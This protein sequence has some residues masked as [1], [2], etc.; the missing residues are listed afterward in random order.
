MKLIQKSLLEG[1][2]EFELLEEEVRVRTKTLLKEKEHIVT[3]AE[4][5]G[6]YDV[7][8]QQAS[9]IVRPERSYPVFLLTAIR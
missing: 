5:A 2:Q 6:F 9:V 1:T 3:L 4:Q 8:V 7:A